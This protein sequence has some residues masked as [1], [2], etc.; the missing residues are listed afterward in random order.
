MR[1]EAVQFGVQ[2]VTLHQV[3]VSAPFDDTTALYDIDT[4]SRPYACQAVGD[5]Q[6]FVEPVEVGVGAGVDVEVATSVGRLVVGVAT[7]L[8]VIVGL[9]TPLSS[10]RWEPQFM[11]GPRSI[12]L[13]RISSSARTEPM[14]WRNR[15]SCGSGRFICP[16][17]WRRLL[18]LIL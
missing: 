5:E 16:R 14:P 18:Q 15:A 17:R 4:V 8:S 11:T 7:G 2:S 12:R 13:V 3:I 6:R 9:G 1:L 10:V